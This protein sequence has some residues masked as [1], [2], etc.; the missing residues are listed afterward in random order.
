[1]FV[2]FD[3]LTGEYL[4]ARYTKSERL[5]EVRQFK[6][7]AIARATRTRLG[8]WPPRYCVYSIDELA[9]RAAQVLIVKHE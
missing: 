5:P 8:L 7:R 1:M 2:I 4:G 9:Q 6:T 3:N